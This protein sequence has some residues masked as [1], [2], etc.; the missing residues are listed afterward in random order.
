MYRNGR[1]FDRE[2]VFLGEEDSET[3]MME[4]FITQYYGS[5]REIPRNIV[6][7]TD[8]ESPEDVE[9]FSGSVRVMLLM[10]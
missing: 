8:V 2:E 6:L 10:L 4:D 1:L 9:R 3:V 7:G 5:G